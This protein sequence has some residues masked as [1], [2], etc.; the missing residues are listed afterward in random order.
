M[1]LTQKN[2]KHI[3]INKYLI[4]DTNQYGDILFK[5]N[6][7]FPNV[8]QCKLQVKFPVQKKKNVPFI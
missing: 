1:N 5:A 7:L 3:I 8:M 4:W 2:K 6:Q